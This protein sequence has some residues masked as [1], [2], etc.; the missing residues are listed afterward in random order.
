MA[1]PTTAAGYALSTPE[2]NN[3]F[4]GKL[5]DVEQCRKDH[6]YFNGKRWLLNRLVLGAGVLRGL[7]I[8]TKTPAELEIQ[9]GVAID[10]SGREIVVTKP[11][12][13]DPRQPT[14]E[15]GNPM[16]DPIKTGIV[17]ISIAYAESLVDPVPALVPSCDTGDE[18]APNTIRE[19]FRIRVKVKSDD[20]IPASAPPNQPT[21]LPPPEDL[22][23]WV[24]RRSSTPLPE[25]SADSCMPPPDPWLWLG[26]ADIDNG[27][28]TKFDAASNRSHIL[29]NALLFEMVAGLAERIDGLGQGRVLRYRSGDGQ[30]GRQGQRLKKSLMVQLV[31]GLG[32]SLAKVPVEFRVVAGGGKLCATVDREE[33]AAEASADP[34]TVMSDRDGV[35]TIAWQLGEGDHQ[36]VEASAVGTTFTVTFCA[37]ISERERQ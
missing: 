27:K 8:V 36:E 37:S 33:D 13:I 9:P 26:E 5:M 23:D 35:A 11:L 7:D 10:T 28:A 31:D 22:H 34:V 3:F 18:C 1:T 32:A 15:S 25:S 2:R 24:S 17:V 20:A 4:Y 29:N 12:T 6:S 14:D 30:V 16:G 21:A 19:E